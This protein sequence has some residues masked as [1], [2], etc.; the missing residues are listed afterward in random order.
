[1]DMGGPAVSVFFDLAGGKARLGGSV[2]A[3]F[4]EEISTILP[5]VEDAVVV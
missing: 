4:A 5:D 2:L 3:Q 1:M